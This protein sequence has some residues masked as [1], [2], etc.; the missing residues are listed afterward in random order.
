MTVFVCPQCR[1]QWEKRPLTRSHAFPPDHKIPPRGEPVT[2]F[3]R[4]PGTPVEV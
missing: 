3:G 1:R 4:C 2:I